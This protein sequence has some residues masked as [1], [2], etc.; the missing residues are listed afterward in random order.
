[1]SRARSIGVSGD[2]LENLQEQQRLDSRHTSQGSQPKSFRFLRFL[3]P[4][5]RPS[6]QKILRRLGRPRR[7]GR[8][9]AHIRYSISG[10]FRSIIWT[11]PRTSAEVKAKGAWISNSKGVLVRTVSAQA[12]AMACAQSWSGPLLWSSL[13][14]EIGV[15]RTPNGWKMAIH[16]KLGSLFC[17]IGL[18]LE[19]Q[20]VPNPWGREDLW[21]LDLRRDRRFEQL[22][23]FFDLLG[24]E[25]DPLRFLDFFLCLFFA[26]RSGL[27]TFWAPVW[28]DGVSAHG[29]SCWEDKCPWIG[30]VT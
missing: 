3:L 18:N 5:R 28:P 16:S 1:M 20:V 19:E 22:L 21:R 6:Q 15:L 27:G 23:D 13:A 8:F 25:L 24:D 14:G 10:S 26:S 9:L 4:C 11:A 30:T 2:H 17:W 12:V 29:G 7:V